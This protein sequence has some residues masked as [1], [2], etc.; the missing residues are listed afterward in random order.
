[1]AGGVRLLEVTL[2]TPAA[3]EAIKRIVDGVPDAILGVGT[4]RSAKD[5]EL[6]TSLG[7]R[8]LISPGTT[9]QI[10]AAA[11]ASRVPFLPGVATASEILH[12]LEAGFDVVKFF[13]AEQA[14]GIPAIKALRGPF[15]NVRFCPTG[16][17]GEANFRD[18]LKVPGIVAVGGS[19]LAPTDLIK[20]KA[21]RE[22]EAIAKRSTSA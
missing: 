14:G 6:A 13:P 16:G 8:F 9:P 2:R 21:W 11:K 18:W 3:P 4:I 12:A 19:W 1:V 20:A 5:V 10:Y 15:P 22:I 7:A 17:I